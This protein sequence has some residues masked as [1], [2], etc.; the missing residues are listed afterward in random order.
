MT[1]R[2]LRNKFTAINALL[3]QAAAPAAKVA[4][5]HS[6]DTINNA[7]TALAK[8]GKITEGLTSPGA[9]PKMSGDWM[10]AASPYR[11]ADAKD[12]IQA[13]KDKGI[14][15]VFVRGNTVGVHIKHLAA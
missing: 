7:I 15:G 13:L 12:K 8:F 9:V 11:W 1:K 3:S 14:N 2:N 6:V 4:P 5:T 10:T